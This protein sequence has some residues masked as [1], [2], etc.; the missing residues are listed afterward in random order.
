MI[1]VVGGTSE[2]TDVVVRAFPL[3]SVITPGGNVMVRESM[4]RDEDAEAS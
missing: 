2:E 4:L 1:P 3:E